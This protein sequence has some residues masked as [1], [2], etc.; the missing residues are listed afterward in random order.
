VPFDPIKPY[1]TIYLELHTR[2]Q[3]HID[4]GNLSELCL[5]KKPTGAFNWQPGEDGNVPHVYLGGDRAEDDG[6]D[7]I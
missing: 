1:H 4:R 3:E 7:Y 2:I 6:F 5:L